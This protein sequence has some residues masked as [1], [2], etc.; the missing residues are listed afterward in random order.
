MS[1]MRAVPF[2]A[3]TP[4]DT[5]CFQ[6]CL[7]MILKYFLSDKEFDWQELDKISAKVEGLWTWPTA[8]LLWLQEHGFVVHDVSSFDYKRFANESEAYLVEHA[9]R[10]KAAVSIAYSDMPQEIALAKKFLKQA[11]SVELR[12]PSISEMEVYLDK[13]Y[14]VCCQ[15]NLRALNDKP[16]YSGH[17]V[18][19]IGYDKDTFTLHDPGLPSHEGRVVTKSQFEKA[20]AYPNDAAKNYFAVKYTRAI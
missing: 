3:N 15:I 10:H 7:R 18:L 1:E 19:L 13:G 12:I 6:A 5:H 11:Q 4:D 2:Y 20:W 9:G 16:G 17:F 8:G 14:L